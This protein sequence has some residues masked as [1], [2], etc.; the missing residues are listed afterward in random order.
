VETHRKKDY[1]SGRL[2]LLK[3]F[4]DYINYSKLSLKTISSYRLDFIIGIIGT[5]LFNLVNF[6]AFG[7]FIYRFNTIAGWTFWELLFLYNIWLLSHSFYATFFRNIQ[8]VQNYVASGEFDKFLLKPASPLAQIVGSKFYFMG[9]GDAI[10]AFVMLLI[11]SFNLKIDWNGV[12]FI[13]LF[14]TLFSA[15]LIEVSI[16]LILSSLSFWTTKTE[17]IFYLIMQLNYSIAQKYP[18][19]I[20]EKYIQFIL[21]FVIPFSFMNFY[22]SIF[23]LDKLD[24]VPF[25]PLLVF[26]APL[27][28]FVLFFVATL[29]WK[30]GIKNYKSTG[31]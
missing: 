8:N 14:L 4:V 24:K 11:C 1:Y 26:A 2:N 6:L 18:L 25:S 7:V 21:T 23:I 9:A 28:G 13:Y 17:G 20:Y 10:L 5:I 30:F 22:P 29:F 27:I 19:D 16:S 12:K 31:S 15:M 3:V